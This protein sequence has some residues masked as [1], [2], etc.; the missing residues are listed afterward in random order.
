MSMGTRASQHTTTRTS[1]NVKPPTSTGSRSLPV[2][3][4]PNQGSATPQDLGRGRNGPPDARPP[5]GTGVGRT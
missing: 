4:S 5:D 2:T 1:Y 3:G